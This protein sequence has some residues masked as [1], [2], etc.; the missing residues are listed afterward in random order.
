MKDTPVPENTVETLE[1]HLERA[2]QE[3]VPIK[4]VLGGRYE[5]PV[6]AMVRGRNGPT[7]EIV[8]GDAVLL[9]EHS[10]VVLRVD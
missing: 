4:L 5:E 3:Q 8:V 7:F 2:R 9:M 10:A 1:T 6:M